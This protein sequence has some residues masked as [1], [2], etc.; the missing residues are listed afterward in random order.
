MGACLCPIAVKIPSRKPVPE[1]QK[2]NRVPLYRNL[3]LIV[4]GKYYVA[5]Y[6]M[7]PC[8]HC[9]PCRRN[10]AHEWRVRLLHEAEFGMNSQV[11]FTTISFSDKNLPSEYTKTVV[12]K[13]M[14]SFFDHFRKT[15]GFRPKYFFISEYGDRPENKHRFHLHGFIFIPKHRADFVDYKSVHRLLE[16]HFGYAWIAKMKHRGAINYSMKYATKTYESKEEPDPACG[17]IISS[18]G[19]GR[20]YAEINAAAL[21]GSYSDPYSPA[22]LTFTANGRKWTYKVPLYYRRISNSTVGKQ[23]V[24]LLPSFER[25][26]KGR[27]GPYEYTDMGKS[28]VCAW[29]S[30]YDRL[31]TFLNPLCDFKQWL[32][33]KQLRQRRNNNSSLKPFERLG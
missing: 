4:S 21:F 28:Y 13:Q 5:R 16:H 7:A 17:L 9:Y 2:D 20:R 25:P 11:L 3:P 29:Q 10:R 14:R 15:F 32:K 24:F 26:V 18:H 22:F 31:N 8:R 19:L 30:Y 33:T 12:S 27:F 1:G 23:R 6:V